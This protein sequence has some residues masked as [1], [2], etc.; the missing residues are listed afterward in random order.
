MRL[1][2]IPADA[3]KGMGAFEN[4]HGASDAGSFANAL[5]RAS[6]TYYGA[7]IRAFLRDLID[8]L[9]N[10]MEAVRDLMEQFIADREEDID[11]AAPE[12]RRALARF[13]LVAAAG[14][15]ATQYDITGWRAGDAREAAKVCFNAWLKERDGS[16]SADLERGVRQVEA[17]IQAYGPSRFQPLKEDYNR[18]GDAVRQHVNDRAGYWTDGDEGREYLILPQCF[19]NE[20]CANCDYKAVAQELIKRGS[21]LPGNDRRHPFTRQARTPDGPNPVW[22]Y[23]LRSTVWSEMEVPPE[24]D[25]E[26]SED[27]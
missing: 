24:Q 16:G 22:V 27:F 5:V 10:A 2:N 13:A 25:Q 1:I 6:K 21:L 19:R 8:D 17:F 11:G 3:G 14:E 20:V 18:F 9:D 15:L 23:W 26:E 7:P 4:L 12:V